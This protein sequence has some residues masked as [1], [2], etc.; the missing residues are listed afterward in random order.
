MKQKNILFVCSGNSCRSPMAEYL[1]KA[2]LEE[3]P[4]FNIFSRGVE[5]ANVYKKPSEK[6][7]DAVIEIFPKSGIESHTPTRLTTK[8]LMENSP[9]ILTMEERHKKRI[10]NDNLD[11]SLE[12]RVFTLKEYSGIY[13]PEPEKEPEAETHQIGFVRNLTQYRFHYEEPKGDISDP[14]GGV[15]SY[16]SKKGE[17]KEPNRYEECRDEILECL[18]MIV[19]GQEVPQK[20]LMA[21]VKERRIKGFKKILE[22]AQESNTSIRISRNWWRQILT[23][24]G[25]EKDLLPMVKKIRGEIITKGLG[26][27]TSEYGYTSVSY[28]H[29]GE[30]D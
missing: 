24:E 4:Q 11:P 22:N 30:R 6:A 7:I 3:D 9:L 10:I 27:E 19:G 5:A 1:L 29:R 25:V 12:R 13:V 17:K 23:G 21:M 16:S 28:S 18:K 2:L 26:I 20:K 8:D 15:Y 14:I